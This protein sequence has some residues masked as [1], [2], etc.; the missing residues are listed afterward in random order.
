MLCEG[1]IISFVECDEKEQSEVVTLVVAIKGEL[2]VNCVML[3]VLERF[4]IELLKLL[5]LMK[6][7][8][9]MGIRNVI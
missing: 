3:K 2:C 6:I 9:M 1:R 7:L 8:R 4:E 5:K